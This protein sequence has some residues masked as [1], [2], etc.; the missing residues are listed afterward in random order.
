MAL[1]KM[2]ASGAR[3]WMMLRVRASIGYA[4]LAMQRTT[5]CLF[6]L[7]PHDPH[8]MQSSDCVLLVVVGWPLAVA[9]PCLPIRSM[10]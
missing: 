7:T 5:H 3:R 6:L 9:A 1:A 4:F 8:G 2:H 10:H